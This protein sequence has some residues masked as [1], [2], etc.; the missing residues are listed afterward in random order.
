MTNE[1][2]MT[3]YQWYEENKG[4]FFW[5]ED[6]DTCS[7]YDHWRLQTFYYNYLR[8][9]NKRRKENASKT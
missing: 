9:F 5:I 2:P 6:V 3:F 7:E 8:R 1:I 4:R